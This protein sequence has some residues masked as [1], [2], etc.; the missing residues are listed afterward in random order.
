MIDYQNN[1]SSLAL[2]FLNI[3]SKCQV[4]RS[5]IPV[6]FKKIINRITTFWEGKK[7]WFSYQKN[8]NVE[9]QIEP[10]KSGWSGMLKNK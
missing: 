5:V 9:S 6:D 4:W 8:L 7:K 2:V 3:F 10:N 1:I